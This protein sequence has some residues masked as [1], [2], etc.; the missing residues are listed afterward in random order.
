MKKKQ[1]KTTKNE[2]NAIW[3]MNDNRQDGRKKEET[4]EKWKSHS[5]AKQLPLSKLRHGLAGP[6]GPASA[7]YFWY[8]CWSV[9][10]VTTFYV[11]ISM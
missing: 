7:C 8:F 1:N 11:G 4:E 6:T 2:C 9:D 10:I 5:Q 3:R